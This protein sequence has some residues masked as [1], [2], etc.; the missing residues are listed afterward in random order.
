MFHACMIHAYKHPFRHVLDL[1]LP[2]C[3]YFVDNGVILICFSVITPAPRTPVPPVG[4]NVYIPANIGGG[5]V[6]GGAGGITGTGDGAGDVVGIASGPGP[7]TGGGGG[8]TNNVPGSG[9]GP[10]SSFLIAGGPGVAG[11]PLPGAGGGGARAGALMGTI[12]GSMAFM[13]SLL[14]AFWQ[15]KPGMLPCFGG[16]GGGGAP[17]M[18]ISSPTPATNLPVAQA[19]GGG[20][21]G[22]AL[23]GTGAGGG[24]GVGGSGAKVTVL[25]GSAS[26]GGGGG[27]GSS[28]AFYYS[29]SNATANA[30]GAGGGSGAG[31]GGGSGAGSGGGVGQYDATLRATG[32]FS[33]KGT[34]IGT[35][36][37]T[38]AFLGSSSSAGGGG[39]GGG[40]SAYNYSQ[41]TTNVYN[42][43]AMGGMGG[44]M[45]GGSGGGSSMDAIGYGESTTAD[46]D[47]A[48]GISGGSPNYQSNAM[49]GGTLSKGYSTSTMSSSYNYQVIFKCIHAMI[50]WVFCII[51][52][53]RSEI[54][55]ALTM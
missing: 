24:A 21:G 48:P 27:A 34:S 49:T 7:I 11:V 46:Y 23:S 51:T 16:G 37:A 38:R 41:T 36:K 52:M 40:T 33:N 50:T 39:G 54:L 17:A 35:P 9:G 13:A 8:L 1:W 55:V 30:V 18:A 6:A 19:L 44:G 47:M 32:T 5:G 15:C 45:G 25:N 31:A 28:S 10:R 4:G 22:A 42:S 2:C 20:P 26:G 12:L 43:N 3:G 29:S 53:C 14:W